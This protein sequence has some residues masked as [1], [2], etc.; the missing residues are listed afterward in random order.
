MLKMG[1]SCNTIFTPCLKYGFPVVFF[2]L[3]FIQ[4]QQKQQQESEKIHRNQKSINRNPKKTTGVAKSP[5][6]SFEHRQEQVITDSRLKNHL[7]L[8]RLL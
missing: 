4:E 1:A 5:K 3:L 6:G 7:E 2:C 8:F